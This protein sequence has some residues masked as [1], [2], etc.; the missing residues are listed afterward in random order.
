MARGPLVS[1]SPMKFFITYFSAPKTARVFQLCVHLQRIEVYCVKENHDAKNYFA[2]FLPFPFSIS[3][4][5]VMHRNV[6]VKITQELLHL[7]FCIH[8]QMVEVVCVK[9]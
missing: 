9:E 1:F 5:N 3:H 4:S 6:C 7:G 8:I 2:F